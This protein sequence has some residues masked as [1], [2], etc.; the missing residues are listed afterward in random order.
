VEL[1]ENRTFDEIKIGDSATLERTLT[2]HDIMLFAVM[3]GDINPAHVDPE[4]AMSSRFR[5]VIGH[6]MWSGALIST[7][8]GT[9]FPGPGTIYLGQNLRFRRPVKVGDTITIKVTAKEM[10]A[11]KGKVMLDTDCVNQDGEVVVS[12][13][14]EVIAPRE[15]VRRPK[16]YLPAVHFDDKEMRFREIMGRVKARELAPVATAIVYP[17]DADSL[18]SIAAA[19]ERG[20]IAPILVGTESLI[21]EVAEAGGVDLDAFEIMPAENP[22]EAAA[23]AIRFAREGRIEG[24]MK[25][26]MSIEELIGQVVSTTKGLRTEG[27][28]SHVQVLDIPNYPKPL[29]ITDSMINIAP[30]LSEKRDICQ[31]AIDLARWLGI[32]APKVAVLAAVETINPKMPATIQAATLC[33]M[34]ERGQI[35]GGILDGP[36]TV[37]HAVSLKA[38]EYIGLRSA[39]AGQADI[40]LAPDLES[41]NMIAKQ[42]SS[43]ADALAAGIVLGARVP[44]ALTSRGDD[45]YSWLASAA[46]VQIVAHMYRQAAV[47][48]PSE[49]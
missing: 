36:L 15:K 35:S 17:A 25:G 29:F 34:A 26:S 14:A 7:V 45:R 21:R 12:G 40:L 37:D 48:M 24:I 30:G 1:I 6:G 4:Y 2:E 42:L 44:I 16:I 11:I 32:P 10:D 13:T 22:R 39:V 5:E 49:Y 19:A 27:R 33:K 8:L 46:L 41:G 28:I 20:I 47:R 9:V 18:A 3:S 38:A 43:L 31:N 23:A